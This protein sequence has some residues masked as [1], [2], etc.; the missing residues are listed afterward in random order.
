VV[1]FVALTVVLAGV[2]AAVVGP[3]GSDLVAPATA[4]VDLSVSGERVRLVHR[5]G[6]PLDVRALRIVVRVD[7]QP[8]AHQ[9]PV[10]F[11]AS[12][13]FR[14]GPTGPFNAEADPT[15]SVGEVAAFRVASTN[16]PPVDPGSRVSVT[17]LLDGH[18][19]ARVEAVA[20]DG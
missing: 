14:G 10:P 18:R 4:A 13:G 1:L 7:G 15:W 6:D 8:L 12:E 11:F 17:L 20:T 16:H 5:G 19:I 3:L 9:P 2:V